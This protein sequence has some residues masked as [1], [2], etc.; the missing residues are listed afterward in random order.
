MKASKVYLRHMAAI[1]ADAITKSNVI[2]LRKIFNA[3]ARRGAGPS[4]SRTAPATQEGEEDLL[5]RAL[6]KEAPRVTGELHATG[7]KLLRS[8]RY[9]RRLAPVAPIIDSL[10]HFRLI[11]FYWLD[12]LHCVPTYRA[13]ATNGR[14]F[15]FRNVPWQSGGDG[16]ELV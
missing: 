1:E 4:T 14:S 15:D 5:W 8:P 9:T 3:E 13:V 2:G 10:D 6:E 16:P 7:L 11:G 12:D